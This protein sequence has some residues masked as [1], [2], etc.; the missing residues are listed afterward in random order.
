MTEHS[1]D[2]VFIRLKGQEYGFPECCIRFFT[3]TWCGLDKFDEARY[4]HSMRMYAADI[5]GRGYIPCPECLEKIER[6]E[7]ELPPDVEL[8]PSSRD[9]KRLKRIRRSQRIRRPEIRSPLTMQRIMA[10]RKA[11]AKEKQRELHEWREKERKWNE[12]TGRTVRLFTERVHSP[13]PPRHQAQRR[14]NGARL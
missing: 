10:K 7:M 2:F 13:P 4:R 9:L 12:A 8:V 6:G 3:E 5:G 11:E 14:R 1:D